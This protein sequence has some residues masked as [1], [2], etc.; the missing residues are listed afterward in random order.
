MATGG[1][2]PERNADPPIRVHRRPRGSVDRGEDGPRIDPRA[3]ILRRGDERA[4]RPNRRREQPE[5]RRRRVV[6]PEAERERAGACSSST[7][8]HD[9]IGARGRADHGRDRGAVEERRQVRIDVQRQRRRSGL[10]VLVSADDDP[11]LH[12]GACG[13]GDPEV[14]RRP[15]EPHAEDLLRTGEDSVDAEAARVFRV[16][17][18]RHECLSAACVPVVHA[19]T[20][21]EAGR[22]AA[23]ARGVHAQPEG[24][25]AR[26]P[27]AAEHDEAR[28]VPLARGTYSRCP[29]GERA[30]HAQPRGG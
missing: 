27:G 21:E 16:S 23:Q 14:R 7:V 25:T 29:D 22:L 3:P 18:D 6:D 10:T 8:E 4:A 19:W 1:E 13:Q 15:A 28:D 2:G 17:V 9:V 5:R 20:T 24:K 30:G 12:R 26:L 11:R